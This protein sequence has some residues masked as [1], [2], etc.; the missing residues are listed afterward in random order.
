MAVNLI[1][2]APPVTE[3]GFSIGTLDS[4]IMDPFRASELHEAFSADFPLVERREPTQGLPIAAIV[5]SPPALLPSDLGVPPR[6][7]FKSESDNEVLQMQERFWSFNW[8]RNPFGSRPVEY[9]G[10]IDL[11]NRAESYAKRLCEW[12]TGRG[13]PEPVPASCELLYTD[14]IKVSQGRRLSDY[15][16]FWKGDPSGGFRTAAFN[17]SWLEPVGDGD[18]GTLNVALTHVSPVTE[19]FPDSVF[20]QVN[21]VAGS[22]VTSW[23]DTF[24][25]FDLAHEAIRNRFEYMLTEE[26]KLSWN[27]K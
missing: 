11:R 9:P 3:V 14:L 19:D 21:F 2:G 7:W 15:F 6:W 16:A 12:H 4:I 13:N 24:E 23:D 22:V 10:Y 25:F 1:D 5:G 26:F 27:A 18:K 8:R 20:F 17:L